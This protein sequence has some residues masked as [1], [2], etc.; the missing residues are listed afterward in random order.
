MLGKI[1]MNQS[2]PALFLLFVF[3][4]VENS[5]HTPVPLFK[6]AP[7]GRGSV[8]WDNRV[9]R[10]LGLRCW[11]PPCCSTECFMINYYNT[12]TLT[13]FQES[14]ASAQNKTQKFKHRNHWHQQTLQPHMVLNKMKW[15]QDCQETKRTFRISQRVVKVIV[16]KKNGD[17]DL[18]GWLVFDK[19]E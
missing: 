16:L 6:P 15:T 11:L 10:C 14:V 19:E 9:V 1:L 7:V 8:I 18:P 5:S 3:V 4:K 13:H 17:T 12:R 2:L